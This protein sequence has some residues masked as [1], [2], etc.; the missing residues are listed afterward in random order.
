[1]ELVNNV[2]QVVGKN[3]DHQITTG[4]NQITLNQ[5]DQLSSGIYF[6]NLKIDHLHKVVKVIKL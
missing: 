4:Y 1:M 3:G 5:F 6:L 2:G